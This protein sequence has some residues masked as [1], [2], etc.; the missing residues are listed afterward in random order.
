[1]NAPS[2]RRSLRHLVTGSVAAAIV[3][4]AGVASAE[5]GRIV[6]VSGEVVAGEVIDLAQGDH[7][8][9][10]MADG[11][12]KAIAWAQIGSFQVGASGA[13]VVGGTPP[14][15]PPP[16]PP[17]YVAP[18]APPP[19]P[20]PPAYYGP[21]PPPPFYPTWSFGLRGGWLDP[22]GNMTGGQTQADGSVS[23]PAPQKDYMGPGWSLEGWV[24]YHFSPSWTIYGSWEHGFLGK[25]SNRNMNQDASVAPQ[26]NFI[27]LGVN[28][29]TNPR[30]VGFLVDVSFGYRWL[31]FNNVNTDGTEQ[32]YTARG[33]DILRLGIGVAIA[34]NEKFRLDAMVVGS[35]GIYNNITTGDTCPAGMVCEVAAQDQ[36]TH[37]FGGLVI[38]GRWDL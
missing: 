11:Q 31:Q 17:T 34:T 3:L 6:L 18:P 29:T 37:T 28:A 38:G 35:A 8:T 13:I 26:T 24:G 15:P 5:S 10:K 27:G 4:I 20:P 19:A 14:P 12:V 33:W 2:S 16:P 1:M 32:K 21:P 22:G 25:A 7:I 36:G 23:T 30:G 9:V